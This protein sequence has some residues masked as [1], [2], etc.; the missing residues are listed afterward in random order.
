[1]P[2]T[3]SVGWR[4]EA[5]SLGLSVGVFVPLVSLCFLRDIEKPLQAVAGS[6]LM[7]LY[8]VALAVLARPSLPYCVTNIL[9][10]GPPSPK[11]TS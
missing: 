8:A 2:F 11:T 4:I 6:G 7:I 10:I 3:G 9:S 5:F 1:M